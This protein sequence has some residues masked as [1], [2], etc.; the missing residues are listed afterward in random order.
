M[1]TRE[2]LSEILSFDASA[3]TKT[4]VIEAHPKDDAANLL[5][6]LSGPAYLEQTEDAYLFRL[7]VPDADG[8]FWVDQLDARFWS[9]HTNMPVG[10]ASRYLRQHVSSRRDLDWI[11]LPSEH[12]RTVW[13][14]TKTRGFRSKFEGSQLLG[15]TGSFDDV[16]LKLT[17]RSADSFLAYLYNNAE[18][19]SAVS[20]DGVEVALDD[21]DFGSINE[22]VDRLGR[23]AVSGDSLEFHLQ[24]VDTVVNRYR[25]LVELCE[26][27]A[28]S[29]TGFEEKVTKDGGGGSI[30]GSPIVIKFS[31]EIDDVEQFTDTL[32]SSREPF[33]L[34][35]VPHIADG[36]AEIEAV[37]LHVGECV[38]IDVGSSWLR[39]YLPEGAC[40]NSVA[41]LASNLQHR[42]DADLSFA[43]PKIDTALKG[44]SPVLS[45]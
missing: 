1:T 26:D 38:R 34:W 27:S 7:W 22:A 14:S 30:S 31:R 20:F 44:A 29:W 23:F 45:S 39:I 24:F 28:I 37:D 9:F 8:C 42:F 5:E 13:P 17:G 15:G 40:G 4:F 2:D 3:P 16:R 25:R 36:V 6:E 43:D 35:G 32:F 19:R 11:W 21:P 33:R 12:L 41:R 18:I 10:P